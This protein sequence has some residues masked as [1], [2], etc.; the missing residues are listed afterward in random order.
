MTTLNECRLYKLVLIILVCFIIALMVVGGL[1]SKYA[2]EHN[3]C[4][5]QSIKTCPDCPI[6]SPLTTS[7]GEQLNTSFKIKP[8]VAEKEIYP[9]D[10]IYDS[11]N[12]IIKTVEGNML[13][14]S[15]EEKIVKL[16]NEN[17]SNKFY[18]KWHIL[19]D[20]GKIFTP[21]VN[22]KIY[23][24]YYKGNNS[25]SLI[26]DQVYTLNITFEFY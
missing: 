19:H 21:L 3:K 7:S 20:N 1:L 9:D 8:L 12:M 17:D 15:V 10:F 18:V 26:E 6:C 14:Y 13:V 5:V 11:D 16:V 22:G 24:L 2:Y 25:L 23:F 4:P